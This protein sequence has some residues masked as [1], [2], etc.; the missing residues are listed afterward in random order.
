MAS[1]QGY[2]NNLHKHRNAAIEKFKNA[3]KY[4][5]TLQLLEK[6][7][8]EGN[9][10]K[11]NTS[12]GPAKSQPKTKDRRS[13]AAKVDSAR[14]NLPPPATANIARPADPQLDIANRQA[15]PAQS[16]NPSAQVS[17]VA[18]ESVGMAHFADSAPNM[19]LAPA[20]LVGTAVSNHWYDRFIDLLLGEDETTPS[21][22]LVLICTHCRLVNG[23]APPGVKELE[24]LGRWRCFSCHGWNGEESEIKKILDQS[25]KQSA[26]SPRSVPAT[27]SSPESD[28]GQTASTSGP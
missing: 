24:D 2:L 25:T 10:N 16:P 3:T 12:T 4:N 19:M 1:N 13:S 21:R 6:Y 28:R 23:Q 7:G 27:A 20:Q 8:A 26:P 17:S 14:T 5:S 15:S 11:E 9:M 22:R 18:Q